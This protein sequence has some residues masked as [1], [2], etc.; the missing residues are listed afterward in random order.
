MDHLDADKTKAVERYMLGD[1]SV[2]EVEE[3]ERHFFDCPQCSE[4]LRALTIFQE[5]ARAVF[6]EQ[7]LTPIPASV[8]A[9]K[10]AAPWWHGLSRGFPP[11]FSP[12]AWGSQWGMAMAALAIGVFA[13]YLTFAGHNDGAQAVWE[14]PLYAQA[15]GEET[16]VAPAADS[17]FYMLDFDKTWDGEFSSYRAEAR[18]ASGAVKFSVPVTPGAPGQAIHVLVPTHKLTSGKYVLVMFGGNGSKE[19]ELALLPYRLQIK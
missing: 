11:L 2:S 10:S 16:V 9:P 19:N 4:E 13:G 6:S 18:D 3:F 5:N 12:S 1:L 7:D 14:Y 15:R 8:Y 17:K